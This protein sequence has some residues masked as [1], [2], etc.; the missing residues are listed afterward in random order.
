MKK[1]AIL[2]SYQNRHRHTKFLIYERLLTMLSH[3]EICQLSGISPSKLKDFYDLISMSSSELDYY[4][5]LGVEQLMLKL[6]NRKGLT[7]QETRVLTQLI[8][9][10]EISGKQ[11]D[12]YFVLRKYIPLHHN[13]IIATNQVSYLVDRSIIRNNHVVAAT[14]YFQKMYRASPPPW[15]KPTDDPGDWLN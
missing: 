10:K 4:R 14:L 3:T 7:V 11:L 12:E 13:D 1:L 6:K 9:N 5:Y 8:L 15:D 2:L